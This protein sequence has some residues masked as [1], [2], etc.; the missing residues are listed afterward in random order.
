MDACL[1]DVGHSSSPLESP[2][3]LGELKITHVFSQEGEGGRHPAR[4]LITMLLRYGR[5]K[6]KVQHNDESSTPVE[7]AALLAELVKEARK[8]LEPLAACKMDCRYMDLVRA[9]TP[10]GAENGAGVYIRVAH[11]QLDADGHIAPQEF[12]SFLHELDE[13]RESIIN[14]FNTMLLSMALLLTILVVLFLV[15]VDH[16]AFDED[17]VDATNSAWDVDAI[18]WL[19]HISDSSRV[20]M[21]RSFHCVESGLFGLCIIGCL[22]GFF[23]AQCQ[24]VVVSAL[25]GNMALLE[26]LLKGGL[27]PIPIVYACVDLPFFLTPLGL[28]F[29]AARHSS[30]AFVVAVFVVP[31]CYLLWSDVLFVR[32]DGFLLLQNRT[33]QKRARAAVARTLA[34]QTSFQHVEGAQ[35]AV[36]IQQDPGTMPRLAERTCADVRRGE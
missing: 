17:E 18:E 15:K 35:Q 23:L 34:E 2:L 29:A 5:S 13:V 27:K 1:P 4:C 19:A 3:G 12:Q 11:V 14:G 20:G 25:P 36:N 21:R 26:Y 22:A 28:V 24:L 6:R 31:G 10:L 9:H 30:I 8:A 7:D 16:H 33:L 32:S